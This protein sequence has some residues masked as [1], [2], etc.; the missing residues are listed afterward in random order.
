MLMQP[1]WISKKM[2]LLL[3]GHYYKHLKSFHSDRDRCLVLGV[4]FLTPV[5]FRVGGLCIHIQHSH[6]SWI[7]DTKSHGAVT[8][9]TL[10]SPIFL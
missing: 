3:N 2:L 4:L 1:K 10:V 7:L 8:N 6:N 9:N 5:H